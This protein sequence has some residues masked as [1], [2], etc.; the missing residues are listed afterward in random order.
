MPDSDPSGATPLVL[1]RRPWYRLHRS[2]W[3][4]MPLPLAIAVVI[5]LP[6]DI[7]WYPDRLSHARSAAIVHGWPIPYLWRTPLEWNN[8]PAEVSAAAVWNVTD[9]VR[10]LRWMSLAIDVGVA[11]LGLAVF[12]ALVEW[13]R[14]RRG[15]FFQFTLREL[16]V[17]TTAAAIIFACWV[18][19]RNAGEELTGHLRRIPQQ[20][21]EVE[22]DFPLW[23][24]NAFGDES[25]SRL[26][27]LRH[28]NPGILWWNA[29]SRDDVQFVVERFP[30]ETEVCVFEPVS[31]PDFSALAT[32]R[33]LQRLSCQRQQGEYLTRFLELLDRLN[34]LRQLSMGQRDEMP[35]EDDALAKI[36]G[37]SHLEYLRIGNGSRLTDRGLGE[38]NKLK[39]LKHLSI[40]K[41][42]LTQAALDRLA[43]LKQLQRLDLWGSSVT[44]ADLAVLGHIDHL[45]ELGL[46][47]TNLGDHGL[48]QLQA[49]RELR[50][51]NMAWTRVTADGIWAM[52]EPSPDNPNPFSHLE[53]IDIQVTPFKLS[54]VSSLASLHHLEEIQVSTSQL[55]DDGIAALQKLSTLRRIDLSGHA[56]SVGPVGGSPIEIRLKNDL[57]DCQIDNR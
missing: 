33:Q 39:E 49:A 24:R 22:P 20:A 11:I 42:N 3:F 55:D 35:V 10:Q 50:Y 1:V 23:I 13:R 32:I 29:A 44:A 48:Q 53:F 9:S 51:L 15:R 45:E 56:G 14:R 40:E 27:L 43:D 26:G 6:G 31:E 21:W 52:V 47:Q 2:T 30:D 36:A 25:L 37:L 17:V 34:N 12:A 4:L 7:G 8:D 41:A 16:L 57:P 18:G 5:V 19:R 54:A 46:G 28:G 38:L